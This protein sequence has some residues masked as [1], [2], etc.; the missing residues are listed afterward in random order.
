[1]Y[2]GTPLESDYERLK[3]RRAL[4][5]ALIKKSMRPYRGT[6]MVSGR[7][8]DE[9]A[10]MGFSKLGSALVAALS[11]R[12]A[13]KDA[14]ALNEK[15]SAGQ[16]EGM[17]QVTEAL[18]G[19]PDKAY[20]LSPDEQFG[21]EQIPGLKTAGQAPN[22]D[23]AAMILAGNPYLQNND[24]A[25]A[26]IN[27][28]AYGGKG[29]NRAY[30][31]VI[32]DEDGNAISYNSRTGEAT[33]IEVGGKGVQ[34]PRY[35][36]GSQ[37]NLNRAK[38]LGT[39]GAELETDPATASAVEAAKQGRIGV[40]P[41]TKAQEAAD[42]AQAESEQARA[43]NAQGITEQV[44]RVE[45]LLAGIGADKPTGSWV[46]SILDGLGNIVGV[47]VPGSIPAER[48]KTIGS[49]LAS[50]P[51]RFEGPQSDH[52]VNLYKEMAGM[53]GND[54]ISTVKRQAKMEEFARAFAKYE[55]VSPGKFVDNTKTT[56]TQGGNSGG[57]SPEEEEELKALEAEFGAQ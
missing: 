8:V 30:S 6:Q 12:K 36:P 57:L 26:L 24:V 7:A 13:D 37:Y 44:V 9:R 28:G 55:E 4:N 5:E 32:Y 48:L 33:P 46:G 38:Q 25:K 17:K 43:F 14:A 45:E 34:D 27:S 22:R 1:M 53:V 11:E 50:K 21:N 41:Q 19:T 51:P 3:R 23:K 15:Y 35:T 29:A 20:Q 40:P 52:D 2:E 56:P 49:Q 47:D 42:K 31:K 16:A 10:G 39:G 54:K 18:M